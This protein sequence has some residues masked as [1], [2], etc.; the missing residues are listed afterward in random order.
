MNIQ[1]KLSIIQNILQYNKI[2]SLLK[3]SPQTNLTNTYPNPLT[4]PINEIPPSSENTSQA[5]VKDRF[6]YPSYD[7]FKSSTDSANAHLFD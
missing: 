3:S 2:D 5:T 7:S 6:Q 4:K 1:H